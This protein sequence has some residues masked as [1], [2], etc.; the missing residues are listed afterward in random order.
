[1]T[2]LIDR[3]TKLVVLVVQIAV[4]L[5]SLVVG[6]MCWNWTPLK[7]FV[8]RESLVCHAQ[9]IRQSTCSLSDKELLLDR[10]DFLMEYL[11]EGK[12]VGVVRWIEFSNAIEPLLKD[13]IT[14]DEQRLVEREIDRLERELRRS[15][16]K[17]N[18]F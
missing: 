13:E 17:S 8:F 14:S 11:E 7:N 3:L 15:L 1:M 16:V 10:L 5:A 9:S 18:E 2:A 12:T 6:L 4:G